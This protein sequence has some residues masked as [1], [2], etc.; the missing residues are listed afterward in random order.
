MKNLG[1]LA[2]SLKSRRKADSVDISPFLDSY[3]KLLNLEE[4]SLD[5][6]NKVTNSKPNLGSR[7]HKTRSV[8]AGPFFAEPAE[9]SKS[10]RILNLYTILH[11]QYLQ[12]LVI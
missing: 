7:L 11:P 5:I 1:I 2:L 10:A 12:H 4:I 3:T 9:A 8:R 6:A